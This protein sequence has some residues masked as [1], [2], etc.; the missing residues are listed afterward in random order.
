MQR[1][2]IEKEFNLPFGELLDSSSDM[3]FIL[4]I[5]KDNISVEYANETAIKKLGYTLKE[6][7]ELGIDGFRKPIKDSKEF[8]KHMVEL[9]EKESLTD[10]AQLT[11]KDKTQFCVEVNARIIQR[12][13]RTYNIALVRDITMRIEFEEELE[14]KLAKKTKQLNEKISILKSYQDAIDEN[15]I[16]TIADKKGI[17]TYVNDN[18]CKLSGYNREEVIGKAHNIVR[19]DDTPDALFKDLW[20]TI[21][22]KKVWRGNIKNKKKNSEYY[23]VDSVIV[24]ILDEES[25]IKEYLSIR[26]DITEL[27]NKQKEIE[28]LAHTDNL[29]GVGNRLALSEIL[30]SY[31]K[32]PLNIALIDINRFNQINNFY[33][34]TIGN[35]VIKSFSQSIQSKLDDSYKIFRL[36]GDEFIILNTD[37]KKESF[38]DKMIKLNSFLSANTITAENKKFNIDTTVALSFEEASSLVTTVNLAS[39]YAKQKGLS[40]NIY[41][42]ETSLE[43]EYKSNIEWSSKIKKALAENRFTI[44]FQPIVDTNTKKIEK[45]EALVRMIDEDGKII[46]PFFFLDKAKKSHQYIEIT[47]IVIEKTMELAKAKDIKC[48]INITIEDIESE[49]IKEFIFNSLQKCTKAQ[50]ITFELVESEGIENFVE[51]DEFIQKVKSFGCSLAI[52]DFGTGYSNFEY[53]LKLNA[54][55]I[56]IDGSLIK[57][58]D[59]NQDSYDIVQTIVG[60]AK[61]KK[62][63]VVAEFVSSE[64]IYKKVKSLGIDFCQGYYFGEPK[65]LD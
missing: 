48:S 39:R 29:T 50:N 45:Y 30:S 15:L 14:K 27:A 40:F 55:T 4:E 57:D 63:S 41:S 12:E 61:I 60:F 8:S 36:Q 17:I 64:S 52:D 56:K 62:L 21:K 43:D 49:Y 51:V 35:N 19:H 22:S 10:Y 37:L 24:P 32:E 42:Q 28:R 5:L 2:I 23:I 20:K 26:Y 34:E 7:Q 3:L 31:K 11:C 13:N 1:K 46:S 54:D 44:F 65:P 53:L 16:L 6:M 25:N 18:F 33:G 47:K 58:I 9:Q 59:T 38:I